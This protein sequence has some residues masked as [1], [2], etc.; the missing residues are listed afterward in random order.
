MSV[1]KT[2]NAIE[3]LIKYINLEDE[4]YECVNL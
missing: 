3:K 1:R 4:I 2:N